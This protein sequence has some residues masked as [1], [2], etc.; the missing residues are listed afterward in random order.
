MLNLWEIGGKGDG[1]TDNSAVF[2]K[3]FSELK[4]RQ[5]GELVIPRGLYL[6]GPWELPGGCTITLEKEA[7]IQFIPEFSRYTPVWTRWEG[8]ECFAMNPLIF[9]RNKADITLRGEGRIDGSGALWWQHLRSIRASGRRQPQHPIEIELAAK[10]PGYLNHPSGGGGRETQFLRPALLQFYEC[11]N[12]LV[13][14][15]TLENSPFWNTHPVYCRGLTF[16][17]VT[18]SNPADAPNTDGL[19]L[20]S[21]EDVLV[22]ACTFRVGDD[23]LALKSGAGEDG[24]RVNRPCRDIRI[25]DCT[26]YAGHGGIVIGSETAGG[27]ERVEVRDCTMV[28]TDRGI[29]IKTRRG[30]GG[31]IQGLRFRNISIDGCLCPFVINAYYRCGADESDPRLFSLDPQDRTPATPVIR[32]IRVE[33]LSARNCRATLGFIAGLPESPVTGLD[34]RDYRVSLSAGDGQVEPGLAAMTAGLP[35]LTN[36]ELAKF[37]VEEPGLG[38]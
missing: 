24:L 20:D 34:I 38:D 26:M 28:D 21:C 6:T 33:G 7:V 18:F 2:A 27:I 10:N 30:R 14:G 19:D 8:V 11:R 35:V 32:D 9:A 37:F 15:I 22:E 36:R 25:R 29:R 31:K 3:A 12:V 17:G 4:G 13:E 5:G 16:R 23:C 1:K